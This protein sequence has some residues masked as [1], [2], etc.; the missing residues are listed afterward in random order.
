MGDHGLSFLAQELD[1][2]RLLRNQGINSNGGVVKMGGNF[3]CF[4]NR[5]QINFAVSDLAPRESQPH[6]DTGFEQ[7]KL[8]DDVMA[9]KGVF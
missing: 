9:F 4:F 3:F 2:V 8:A 6:T 7:S 5:R 1:K